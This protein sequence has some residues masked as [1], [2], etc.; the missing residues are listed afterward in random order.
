MARRSFG[1]TSYLEALLRNL[2]DGDG[3]GEEN[4]LSLKRKADGDVLMSDEEFEANFPFP[5]VRRDDSGQFFPFSRDLFLQGDRLVPG[6]GG[7]FGESERGLGSPLAAGAGILGAACSDGRNFPDVNVLKA[8]SAIAHSS[9]R[10]QVRGNSETA[11]QDSNS[12]ADAGKLGAKGRNMESVEADSDVSA[13]LLIPNTAR[14]RSGQS[15][16]VLVDR[17]LS[18]GHIQTFNGTIQLHFFVRTFPDS[19]TLVLHANSGDTVRSLHEKIQRRMGI[20]VSEQRLIYSGK[21]L[22]MEHTLAECG[23]EKDSELHLVGRIRSTSNYRS[24]QLANEIVSSIC[25][26]MSENLDLPY[27]QKS[28]PNLVSQFLDV[29]IAGEVTSARVEHGRVF[30][31]SGAP[32]ALCMLYVS[33]IDGN[34]AC[35]EECIQMLL[36]LE[37]DERKDTLSCYASVFLVICNRLAC[38]AH[39]SE[40]YESCRH[41]LALSL[42]S[43]DVVRYWKEHFDDVDLFT[44]IGD[45][46]TY[47]KELGSTLK[48]DFVADAESLLS[49][50][51]SNAVGELTAFMR[52]VRQA[53]A[54]CVGYSGGNSV[55]IEELE[56]AGV[57]KEFYFAL[58]EVLCKFRLLLNDMDDLLTGEPAVFRKIG[59]EDAQKVLLLLGEFY[60]LSKIFVQ[61]KE[62][63]SLLLQARSALINALILCVKEGDG[64]LWIFNHKDILYGETIEHLLFAMFPDVD[65]EQLGEPFEMLI[66]RSKLLE[67]SYEYVGKSCSSHLKRDILIGFKDE[68]A[69]GPGVVREWFHLV[70]NELFDT[71]RPL[72]VACSEDSRRFFPNPAS[73]VDPMHLQYFMFCG[74][75]IAMA[76]MH[77]VQ[78]NVVLS[79]SF[80][81]NLAGKRVTLEDIKEEEREVYESCKQLLEMDAEC[82][83]SGDLA[84][85]FVVEYEDMG[86]RKSVELCNGGKNISVNSSNRQLFVDLL[87]EHRFTKRVSR[88][89][90]QF[91]HGFR[92]ILN[93][94]KN[95]KFFFQIAEPG[96][97]DQMLHGG[98]RDISVDEW[99]EHTDYNGYLESDCQIVWFWQVVEN[100]SAE[101]QQMFLSFWTS[102][103]H[104]PAKGFAGLETNLQI[105]KHDCSPDHLPSAHTCFYQLLLPP[106]PSFS[107]MK[108]RLHLI[109]QNHIAASFGMA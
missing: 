106:Y 45:V 24:W 5:K 72:F 14:T 20:P 9:P 23:I 16:P 7:F 61:E 55:P 89:V 87:I 102:Q 107:T 109:C 77:R 8:F 44:L 18:C 1:D 60:N 100:M 94:P 104:L 67:V 4:R 46:V 33:S 6:I 63:L 65:D 31:Y 82:L 30:Q 92:D 22:G 62:E 83:D 12:P 78:V 96:I 80:V 69:T 27:L 57:M 36:A 76:L 58:I 74:R 40:L 59:H 88:Q 93:N 47:V 49:S 86:S 103:N 26:M 53:I 91:S 38:V 64:H 84:L 17:S 41:A 34:K 43:V 25:R 3:E 10:D 79:R 90:M 81:L 99:K 35:A 97:L 2:R 29:H 66:D 39:D 95:S 28:V 21:Q 52:P 54:E 101:E 105:Y 85:S 13:D 75:M 98:D 19:R 48:P 108:D 15:S 73:D 42:E 71:K 68:E 32:L 11:V 70:F 56:G 51:L 50:T 37:S